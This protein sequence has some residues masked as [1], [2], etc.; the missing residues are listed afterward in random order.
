MDAM[1]WSISSIKKDRCIFAR[2]MSHSGMNKFLGAAFFSA[3]AVAVVVLV[4]ELRWAETGAE[5]RGGRTIQHRDPK[6]GQE[7]LLAAAGR[8]EPPALWERR[9]RRGE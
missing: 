8:H 2:G 4:L 1:D 3:L 7:L 5:Q 9:T 6:V